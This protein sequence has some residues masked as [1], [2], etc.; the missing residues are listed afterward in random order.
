MARFKKFIICFSCLL[1]VAGGVQAIELKSSVFEKDLSQVRY[2]T[3]QDMADNDD[4]SGINQTGDDGEFVEQTSVKGKSPLKAMVLSMA[5]PGLGQ[6][7]NGSKLR[8]VLYFGAEI[9]TWAMYFKWH[10]EGNDMTADFEAF[11]KGGFGARQ[12]ARVPPHVAHFV[13]AH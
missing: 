5:V 3:A 10:G 2:F 4:F 6:W 13:Q 9:A 11:G 7:Y 1:I 12:I 8:S